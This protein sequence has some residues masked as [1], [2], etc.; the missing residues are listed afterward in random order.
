VCVHSVIDL[1]LLAAV[2][3]TVTTC[4]NDS[5]RPA[6]MAGTV[7]FGGQI[8]LCHGTDRTPQLIEA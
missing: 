7:E 1:P 8:D 3:L 2:S 4:R 5:R 6:A